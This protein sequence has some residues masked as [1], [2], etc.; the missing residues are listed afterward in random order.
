[1]QTD[2]VEQEREKRNA[3]VDEGRRE[4]FGL[5]GLNKQTIQFGVCLWTRYAGIATMCAFQVELL[6]RSR[7]LIHVQAIDQPTN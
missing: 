1:M 3:E 6:P 5:F 4:I 2:N 7:V